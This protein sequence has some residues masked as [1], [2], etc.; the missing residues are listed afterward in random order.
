MILLSSERS[1]LMIFLLYIFLLSSTFFNKVRNFLFFNFLIFLLVGSII[2]KVEFLKTRYFNNILD[3]FK[4]EYDHFKINTE[5]QDGSK[6]PKYYIFTQA[7]DEMIRTSFNMFK[8]KPILGHGSNTFRENCDEFNYDRYKY[9]CNT[10]PHNYYVQILAENGI[11]GF[12]FLSSLFL[13]FCFSL[14]KNF[15]KNKKIINLFIIPNILIIW[16]LLPHGNFFNNW[17]SIIIF[18]NLSIYFSINKK[19]NTNE[20]NI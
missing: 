15:F 16:P 10:H 11:I 3:Q 5:R 19:L 8:K 13:Y 20:K 18:L 9:A 2:Y 12:I 6:N 17:I 1:A 14:I 4:I 7:H